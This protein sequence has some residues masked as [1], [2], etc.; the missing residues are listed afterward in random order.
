MKNKLLKH[1]ITFVTVLCMGLIQTS[2]IANAKTDK[3][4]EKITVQPGRSATIVLRAPTSKYHKLVTFPGTEDELTK[5]LA[6][7]LPTN[8]SIS[9]CVDQVNTV[10]YNVEIKVIE[11]K[12]KSGISSKPFD[13]SK[14]A[15][16]IG[17]FKSLFASDS[18]SKVKLVVDSGDK[19][20]SDISGILD[21]LKNLEDKIR[22]TG[23]LNKELDS[24]LYRTED[25][26]F[27]EGGANKVKDGFTKIQTDAQ[28]A[29]QQYFSKGTPEAIYDDAKNVIQKIRDAAKEFNI[30]A[31]LWC[32]PEDLS[33]TSN[34]IATAF[35]TVAEKLRAIQTATWSK[36]DTETR[37]LANKIKFTCVFTPKEKNAKLQP[38][39]RVVTIT[40]VPTGWIIKGTQGP[41]ISGL[42]SKPYRLGDAD[43]TKRKILEL[44][45][46]FGDHVA[47]STGALVHVYHSEFKWIGL[48]GGLGVDGDRK[49]QIALGGSILF[50]ASEG[51]LFA[52]TFGGILGKVQILDGYEK[53][54]KITENTLPTKIVNRPS[55]FSAITYNFDSLL[56]FLSK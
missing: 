32:L 42:I 18:S 1:T 10:L 16:M 12:P 36:F 46:K 50:N 24:L 3:K 19:E 48:T 47:F 2:L 11:E 37:I 29:T 14:V 40:G 15:D 13:F 9:F 23:K 4:T 39:T 25:S 54:D 38:I 56:P 17:K 34:E 35:R 26:K 5:S 21:A 7:S 31:V 45:K 55:W 8:T 51:Q 49:P 53:N 30:E 33:D 22:E 44:D 52:L 20:I 43:E 41:F 28:N 6:L 27:Y